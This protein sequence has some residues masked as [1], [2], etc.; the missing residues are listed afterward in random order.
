MIIQDGIRRMYQEMEDRFYYICVYNENY[1][2]PPMPGI[3][4]GVSPELRDG[5]LKGIYKY[6]AS[7]NGPAAAQLFGS[8]S[9][10][11]EAL[12]AQKI[13]AERYQIATDVW[14][15][16]SYNEANLEKLKSNPKNKVAFPSQAQ[17]DEAQKLLAPVREEWV[18]ASERHRELKA[19]L[20][21]E[22]AAVR[23]EGKG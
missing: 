10:L 12:R 5:I 3:E 19:A 17:R 21:T 6:R 18:A 14:S 8:G 13:L 9:I 11:N 4:N 1:I 15:V 23:G 16:T 7:E 2:Q 20:D 22:L